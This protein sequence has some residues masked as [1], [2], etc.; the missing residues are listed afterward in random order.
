MQRIDNVPLI[1]SPPAAHSGLTLVNL[2]FP[3]TVVSMEASIYGASISLPDRTFAVALLAQATFC[4]RSLSANPARAAA[5]SIEVA[6]A[7]G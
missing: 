3:L 6:R 4:A 7:G 5:P 1:L 2:D